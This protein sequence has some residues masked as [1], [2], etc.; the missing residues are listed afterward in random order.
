MTIDIDKVTFAQ[1]KE[2]AAMVG[3]KKSA[4]LKE[5]FDPPRAAIVRAYSGVFFGYVVSKTR[6]G[7][8]LKDA[9]QIWS[10]DS[11]GLSEKV[12][13]TGDIALR[14]VGSGSRV[15]SPVPEKVIENGNNGW[16]IDFASPD[17]VRVIGAQKW[18]RK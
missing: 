12:N 14:G 18:A 4:P 8:V 1:M 15:S 17:A 11:A 3:R 6:T 16:S 5:T 2:I 9:R 10:W 7:C 13:T